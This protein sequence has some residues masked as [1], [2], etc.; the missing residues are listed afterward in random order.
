MGIVRRVLGD[1]NI[2]NLWFIAV[3]LP[4]FTLPYLR[5]KQYK[6]QAFQLMILASTL[7]LQYCLVPV[8][9]PQHIL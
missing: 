2:S 7:L 1:A 6:N 9:N 3:G 4:L 8:P 5:I